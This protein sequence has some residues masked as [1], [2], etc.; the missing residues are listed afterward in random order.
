MRFH[1]QLLFPKFFPKTCPAGLYLFKI[2]NGNTRP[3]CEI[4]SKLT[5][6]KPKRR[7]YRSG[8]FILNFEQIPHIVMVFQFLALNR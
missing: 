8:V 1:N 6:T 3:M 5:V 2:N 4:R 7:C